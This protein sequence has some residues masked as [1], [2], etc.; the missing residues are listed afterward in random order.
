MS[1]SENKNTLQLCDWQLNF[2]D[3]FLKEK[4]EKRKRRDQFASV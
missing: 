3:P 1:K 4:M 2:A